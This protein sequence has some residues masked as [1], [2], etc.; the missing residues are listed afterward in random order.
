MTTATLATG[1]RTITEARPR[2]SLE[3][4]V[5]RVMAAIFPAQPET[6]ETPGV[7]RSVHE[8]RRLR[9]TGDVD[10]ALAVLAG[11]DTAKAEKHEARW[12]FSEWR[13]LVKR[14]FGDRD[15]LVYSQGAGQAAALVPHGDGR[16]RSRRSWG[17]GGR[18]ASWSPAAACGVCGP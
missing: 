12:A 2:R 14:R 7:A 9:Q 17:C 6:G 1:N 13:Q 3:E 15:A 5:D 16:L 10:D 8:A 4:L 18:P 11:M